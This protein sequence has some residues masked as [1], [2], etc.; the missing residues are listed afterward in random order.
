MSDATPLKIAVFPGDG[1]GVE[2]MEAARQVLAE[3][4]RRIGGFKCDYQDLPAGAFCYRDTGESLPKASVAEAAKADAILLGACGWPDIR[5]ADGTEV[6]PQV[7]LRFLFELYAGVRPIRFFPGTPPVL[8]SQGQR[9]INFIIIRESTE[10]LFASRGSGPNPEV[11]TETLVITRRTTERLMRFGFKLAGQRKTAGH[12][13]VL[14]CVDKANIFSSMAFFR[15]IYD[16]VGLDFPEVGKDYSYVDAMSH[17]MVRKPWDFDVMVMEN[18]FGDILSDLGAGLIGG[19]GM[20]PSADIGEEFAVFQPS[21]GTGPD[22]AGR[23]VANP[24]AMVLSGA[25]MYRHLGEKRQNPSLIAAAA[26]IDSAVERYVANA[27]R[28]PQD[29]GGDAPTAEV[30][31]LIIKALEDLSSQQAK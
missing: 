27:G 3:A 28:L 8:A 15:S 5:L 13:G 29:L 22:I 18:M 25:M 31:D 6:R 7:E 24:I 14:I 30:T 1:I 11:A 4:E 19:M 20:A 16:Q 17:N 10:G 2:V 12:P 26:L 21:H 23:G 9:P